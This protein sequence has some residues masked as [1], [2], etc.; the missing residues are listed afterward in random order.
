MGFAMTERALH[1]F[2]N[3]AAGMGLHLDGVDAAD[4]YIATFPEQ[5]AKAIEGID[6]AAA[7][8]APS[9][10]TWCRSKGLTPAYEAGKQ[11]PSGQQAEPTRCIVKAA[12]DYDALVL[13][14]CCKWSGHEQV[15]AGEVLDWLMSLPRVAA[16]PTA[17]DALREVGE[18]DCRD[19]SVRDAYDEKYGAGAF[20]RALAGQQSGPAPAGPLREAVEAFIYAYRKQYARPSTDGIRANAP[21]RK[22]IAVLNAAF[23]AAS[24]A[25]R[26]AVKEDGK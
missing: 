13:A 2:L 11:A 15:I 9:F 6:P 22:E 19:D 5:Y 3:A 14:F 24:Q 18:W 4:L 21:M 8:Q 1:T 25:E 23:V 20:D 17:A 7:P 10:E 12:I 26:P 16:A